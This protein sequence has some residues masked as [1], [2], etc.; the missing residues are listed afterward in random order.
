MARVL[1]DILMALDRGDV[2]ALALLDL[3]AAFDTRSITTFYC[4]VSVN[5]TASAAWRS[6]GSVR[7]WLII[8]SLSV[9]LEHSQR[10]SASRLVCRRAPSS[11]PCYLFCTP[12]ISCR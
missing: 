9:I 4:T 6:L 2:A 11:G 5:H 3:S 7:T 1:S 10:R 8:S 12:P